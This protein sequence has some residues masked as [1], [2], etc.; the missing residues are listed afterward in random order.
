MNGLQRNRRVLYPYNTMNVN[1]EDQ[2]YMNL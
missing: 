1:D 2:D